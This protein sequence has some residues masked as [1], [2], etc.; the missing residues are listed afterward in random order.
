MF[1]S[2]WKCLLV[3][4][5]KG[6]SFWGK[7]FSLQGCKESNSLSKWVG[8]VEEISS[9]CCKFFKCEK[10]VFESTKFQSESVWKRVLLVLKNFNFQVWEC[11]GICVQNVFFSNG[12]LESHGEV[13]WWQLSP[14]EVQNYWKQLEN[15][16]EMKASRFMK[17]NNCIN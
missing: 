12:V 2:F 3:Q 7:T 1:L 13:W 5:R 6:D 9:R 17:W 11:S 15:K 14:L 16:Q 8:G 4:H 10:L